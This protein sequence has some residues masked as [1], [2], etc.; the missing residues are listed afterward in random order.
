MK[1]LTDLVLPTLDADTKIVSP[2]GGTIYFNT[3]TKTIRL[4]T[5]T[6]WMDLAASTGQDD[7]VE[8]GGSTPSKD[9][10]VLWID[11]TEGGGGGGSTTPPGELREDE[12]HI[13]GSTPSV[14]TVVL[15]VD[16]VSVT[17]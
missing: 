10:I 2:T 11:P 9:S 5:G 15:W 12:V 14:S 8:V 13:G 6:E 4:Y 16:Q 7:E 1:F 17:D 3:V